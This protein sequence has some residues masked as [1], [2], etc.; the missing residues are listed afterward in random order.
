MANQILTTSHGT[1]REAFGG[2]DWALFASIS[3]IWGSSFLFMAIGLDSFHPGLVTWLRIGFGASFMALLPRAR[4]AEIPKTE[5]KKIVVLGLIWLAIP[6]VIFPIAQQWI[7]SS[8]TGMLNGATPIFTA[9]VASVLLWQ[10]PGRLQ[11]IGLFVGL[12]GILSIALPSAGESTNAAIGVVLVMLA[13][14]CYAFATNI[15]APLQQNYGSIAVMARVQ[16]VAL[17]IVTPYGLYGLTQS[18][19]SWPSLIAM[20]AVGILGTGFALVLM[21][22]LVGSVGP[23]RASF[24][25]YAYPVVALVLGVV[26]RDEIV[27]PIAIAGIALVIAGALIA[28]RSEVSL[29]PL[30]AEAP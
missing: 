1:N 4:R 3:T 6:F 14:V 27:S 18:E 2:R 5:R 10:L 23:T 13:T 24:V 8:V 12:A 17:A 16:W 28:S 29:K 19:F 22:S 7:D 26:F 30:P 21:G 11:I 9:V 15:V 25:T 20:S